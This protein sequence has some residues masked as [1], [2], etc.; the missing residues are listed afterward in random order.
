MKRTSKKFLV[1]A[2]LISLAT[3]QPAQADTQ[4]RIIGGSTIGIE[5]YP[6]TVALLQE[7]VLASTGSAFQAQFCGG[8]L[9]QSKW[10]L[11]AAHCLFSVQMGFDCSSLP[12][13]TRRQQI[14]HHRFIRSCR[15]W[16]SGQ[17]FVPT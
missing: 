9:I 12:L 3:I 13:Q 16:R 14:K 1:T 10:V 15:F 7:A 2:A 5:S 17:S 6:S 4:A 8:T 11:T